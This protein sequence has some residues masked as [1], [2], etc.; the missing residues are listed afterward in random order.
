MTR[1]PARPHTRAM[2][3]TLYGTRDRRGHYKPKAL[4][5]IA[6]L[7]P[8]RWRE[9]PAW[10]PSYFLPWNVV[11]AASAVLYWFLFIPPVETLQTFE[12]G[13]V[14][15]LYLINVIAVAL[16]YGAFEFRLY[17]IRAQGDR[18]KYN[19]RFPGDAKSRQFWF[20]N[21]NIDNILRTFLFGVS[22]WTL[23]GA[24]TL[25]AWANTWGNWLT[26]A[27]APIYLA[28]VA[29]LVSMI[30]QTH[31]YAIH[32][33]IHTPWLY[34]H[35][36]S[37]HHK[38]VNPSPWSSLAMHPAEHALYFA[39]VFYH[40]LLPSHPLIALYQLHKAGFG[41]IPGHI[42]FDK[43]EIGKDGAMDLH[44]YG[45]YLH[46]KYF[47]VNYGDGLVPLDKLFGTYHDGSEEAEARM[48]ARLA[49]MR[50]EVAPS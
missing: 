30:H 12:P 26:F 28:I 13:W 45:H 8:P 11:F 29:L 21:Q 19:P 27:D 44:A 2:D 4:L 25:W 15:R 37:I 16:F 20:H 10:L 50:R 14:L 23:F 38:A 36:H 41:A 34:R 18:F 32:R 22:I 43:M 49:K 35:V 33:L 48:R 47:E 1:T 17:W 9:I 5:K 39:S 3:E 24:L 7:Y 42:G 31:F 6:P 40:V 46:H